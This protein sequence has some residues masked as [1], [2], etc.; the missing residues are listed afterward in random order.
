MHKGLQGSMLW[1]PIRTSEIPGR[2]NSVK[3]L[4]LERWNKGRGVTQE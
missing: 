1:I 3:A 2:E 4:G